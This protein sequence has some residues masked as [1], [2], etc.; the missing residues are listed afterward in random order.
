MSALISLFSCALIFMA[1]CFGV[2]QVKRWGKYWPVA[3]VLVAIALV[4]PLNNWLLIEFVR[5]FFSD[6]SITTMF[7]VVCYL[8]NVVRPNKFKVQISFKVAVLLL[9][10]FMFPMTLGATQFDPFALG[11]SYNQAYPYLVATCSIF[12]LLF[13]FLGQTQ[14]ALVLALALIANGLKL[15]ES[16]N[17]WS[18]IIDPI[19]VIICTSSFIINGLKKLFNLQKSVE[20]KNV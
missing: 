3:Y 11:Y 4:L 12:G 8:F 5:G 1:V 14:L 2:F 17:L 15:Y 16:E 13:W 9:G 18:Y 19:A 10:L 6:L 7:L 20:S